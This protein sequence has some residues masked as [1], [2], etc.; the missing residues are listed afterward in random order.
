MIGIRLMGGLGNMLFQVAMGETWRQRGHDVVYTDMDKNLDTISAKYEHRRHAHEYKSLFP[1][2]NWD[3]HKAPINYFSKVKKV[4]FTYTEI[5]P[6]DGYEY[7]GY[8]QSE[9]FWDDKDYIRHLFHMDKDNGVEMDINTCS[10]H[11]RRGDYLKLSEYHN[12]L[13]EVYYR[14][15]L[16]TIDRLGIDRYLVF[17][18][19]L[20]WCRNTFKGEMFSFINAK[21]YMCLFYM[22]QCDHNIIANSSLSWW[23]AWLGGQADRVVVAPEKW[24]GSKGQDSR[25]IIPPYWTKL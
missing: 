3:E 19:D 10:V 16:E 21:D 11:V 24:F 1:N 6:L 5:G 23:G 8:F 2:F 13:T 22:T 18:D 7:V 20:E 17:S 14:M 12:N 4:P 9:K 25:D 15:A